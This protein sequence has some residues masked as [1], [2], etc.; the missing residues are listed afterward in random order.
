MNPQSYILAA[1]KVISIESEQ[2]ARLADRLNNQFASA[3]QSILDCRGRVVVLGVGKSSHVGAK[4]AATLASTGTPAFFVHAGEAS[5]G[6]LGMITADDIVIAISNSGET[7]ELVSLLPVIKKL[8]V[9]LIA[10]CGRQNSSL[11]TVADIFLDVSVTEEACPLGLAPTASTTAALVMGDALAVSLLQARNFT[12]ADFA[13]THPG[14]SLGKRLLLTVGDLMQTG[15]RVPMVSENIMVNEALLEVTRK[16]FGLTAVVN[17]N[18]QL[19]GIFTDGDL[20][21]VIDNNLDVRN[22]IISEVMTKGGKTIAGKSL[23][24]EALQLMEKY[25]ITVLLVLDDN[26]VPCGVLH[27]YELLRAGL[28]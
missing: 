15:D 14:G 19:V 22:T 8:S 3:C 24:F 5:H 25:K 17:A 16:G 6:D 12:P 2:I 7:Q 20:R 23:A 26:K 21:R 11:A 18:H 27:M 9:K 10:I 1:K 28:I 4:I 13:K